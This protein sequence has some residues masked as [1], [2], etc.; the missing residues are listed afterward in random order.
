MSDLNRKT[1]KALKW[2][3]INQVAYTVTKLIIGIVLARLLSPKE[4]GLIAMI[5]VV[6]NFSSILI[7]SGFKKTIIQRKEINQT[8]L[9]TIF[10]FNLII[11]IAC[12]VLTMLAAPWISDF[13]DAPQLKVLTYG[14]APIYVFQAA[15][16]VQ[17]GISSRQ[18][19][20]KKQAIAQNISF[21]FGGLTGVLLAFLDFGVWSLVFFHLMSTALNAILLFV[22]IR[23][24][25]S[26]VFRFETIKKV[27]AYSSNLLFS[28]L[29]ST[30]INKVDVF[31]VGKFYSASVLG[32][33]SKSKDYSMIPSKFAV[34][35]VS[36]SLF[37]SFS[38]LRDN[39]DK[40][41][42]N[43]QK[44]LE[45]LILIGVLIFSFLIINSNAIIFY[46][47]G[48]QWLDMDVY[49]KLSCI[50]AFLY[51]IGSINS[52]SI[53]AYGRSDIN[54]KVVIIFG[55]LRLFVL[56]ILA[57]FNVNPVWLLVTFI[58]FMTNGFIFRYIILSKILKVQTRGLRIL[59]ILSF[60]VMVV[61]L[62]EL[63]LNEVLC[64]GYLKTLLFSLILLI[65]YI[66]FA[67]LAGW[68]NF[69]KIYRLLH[70]AFK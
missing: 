37:P 62:G 39:Q 8:D 21:L 47:L 46:S 29:Y 51:L 48:E 13:Y 14:I 10:Y 25:P 67:H 53:D 55:S 38:L 36:K 3:A 31:I 12:M 70:N 45:A 54:F 41:Y 27:W 1:E 50:I 34:M 18:F 35:V 30:L 60:S 7:D 4:F 42:E 33:Y 40:F 63:F 57:Y 69:F 17:I 20:F 23:W 61:T 64:Y 65:F 5:L 9:S 43:N 32:L 66:C 59:L 44:A 52:S 11:G 24:K 15:T 56:I 28:G 19:E 68:I 16:I 6:T 49:F 2:N 58:L 26:I 22:L